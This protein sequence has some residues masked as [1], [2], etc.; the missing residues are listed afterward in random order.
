MYM[1]V[2]AAVTVRTSVLQQADLVHALHQSLPARMVRAFFLLRLDI[3]PLHIHTGRQTKPPT[4]VPA[5]VCPFCV[6]VY[7]VH[8]VEDA[9]HVCM[10]CPL[11][12]VL[13]TR[14]FAALH[15]L[16]FVR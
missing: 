10:E 9:Y 14:V 13:C 11:Y 6:H 12:G 2:I 8:A 4:P 16:G 5:R 1:R 3:A 15:K 7:G